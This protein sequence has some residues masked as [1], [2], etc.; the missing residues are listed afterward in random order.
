[1]KGKESLRVI[2]IFV[3]SMNEDEE[4]NAFVKSKGAEDVIIKPMRMVDTA[5]VT[6]ALKTNKK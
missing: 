1:M 2:P 3:I 6:A 4:F 5:R